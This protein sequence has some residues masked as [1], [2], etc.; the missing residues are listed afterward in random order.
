MARWFAFPAAKA[1]SFSEGLAVPKSCCIQS[2]CSKR[3]GLFLASIFAARCS[4]A[5]I[6]AC[7]GEACPSAPLRPARLNQAGE[8]SL[9]ID[10]IP[11]HA[12]HGRRFRHP[13]SS[14][15]TPSIA[16]PAMPWHYRTQ[17]NGRPKQAAPLQS[18]ASS[19]CRSCWMRLP[20]RDCSPMGSTCRGRRSFRTTNFLCSN[21]HPS[22]ESRTSRFQFPSVAP[23]PGDI[24]VR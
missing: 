16:G 10:L 4:V 18:R 6:S 2:N 17:K 24:S 19:S 9:Q 14:G 7:A 8:A 11:S 3:A 20:A 23:A 22:L 5:S 13:A 15:R 21:S 12:A 1:L